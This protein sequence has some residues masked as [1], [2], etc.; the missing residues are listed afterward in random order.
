MTILMI[1]IILKGLTAKIQENGIPNFVLESR[2]QGLLEHTNISYN[3]DGKIRIK[4]Q[5]YLYKILA[6]NL[7]LSMSYLTIKR[8]C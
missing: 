3:T 8:R 4:P 1:R 2:K 5:T 6:G 7:L